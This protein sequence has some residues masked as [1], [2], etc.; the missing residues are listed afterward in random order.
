MLNLNN[1]EF[2]AQYKKN[3]DSM[4]EIAPY[5]E[6][7]IPAESMITHEMGHM[8]FHCFK[9]YIGLQEDLKKDKF[10]KSLYS[11]EEW[12]KQIIQLA[13]DKYGYTGTGQISP[14]A[15]ASHEEW[16]AELFNITFCG[17]LDAAHPL[18]AALWDLINV[19]ADNIQ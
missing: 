17:G 14:Y 10:N 5:I 6:K 7:L 4:P 3:F 15:D 12:K 13:K 16:F 1:A 9:K 8:Y 19:L 2:N 11:L 18:C